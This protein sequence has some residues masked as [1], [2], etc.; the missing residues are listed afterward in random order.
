EAQQKKNVLRGQLWGKTQHSL[1]KNSVYRLVKKV[2]VRGARKIVNWH[3]ADTLW[4]IA[5]PNEP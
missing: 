4:R 2:Q 3:M 5:E 1:L